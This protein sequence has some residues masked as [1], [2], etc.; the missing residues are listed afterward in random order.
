[1]KFIYKKSFAFPNLKKNCF[2]ENV[3]QF[4]HST[5][6]STDFQVKMDVHPA[7]KSLPSSSS[8]KT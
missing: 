3:S 1:M 2:L 6:L 4:I 8:K 5:I 7:L